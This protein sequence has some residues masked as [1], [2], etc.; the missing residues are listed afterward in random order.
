[1]KHSHEIRSEQL[2]VKIRFRIVR[3]EISQDMNRWEEQE[4][5]TVT[6]AQL[7]A[8]NFAAMDG[9]KYLVPNS[10]QDTIVEGMILIIRKILLEI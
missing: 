8:F 9:R 10:G 6:R 7:Q 1:M 2:H 5:R 4:S 3:D